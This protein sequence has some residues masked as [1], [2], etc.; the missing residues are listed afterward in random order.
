MCLY[1]T[2]LS[3]SGAARRRALRARLP[4]PPLRGGGNGAN[5]KIAP[6]I[7]TELIAL[8]A[9]STAPTLVLGI[10]GRY[11]HALFI[12]SR[13]VLPMLHCRAADSVDVTHSESFVRSTSAPT[14]TRSLVLLS[15]SSSPLRPRPRRPPPP[16][17]PRPPHRS[18]VKFCLRKLWITTVQTP[19]RV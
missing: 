19:T 18:K 5:M 3:L 9:V 15:P 1:E 13:V 8:Q 6:K 16:T 14:S 17:P 4:A 12:Q 2:R 10:W 11:M 7:C